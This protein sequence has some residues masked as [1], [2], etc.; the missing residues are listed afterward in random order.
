MSAEVAYTVLLRRRPL[1]E[2][3]PVPPSRTLRAVRLLAFAHQIDAKIRTGEYA[4]LADVARQLGLTRARVTQIVNLTLLAPAIQQAILTW[5]PIAT[6]RDPISER[7]LRSIVAE[8]V[9]AVQLAA[10]YGLLEFAG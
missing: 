1:A 4:E 5:P 6:G 9:W 3:A 8:P 2:P 7:S 10:W